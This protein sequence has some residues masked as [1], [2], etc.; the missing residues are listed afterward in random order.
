M[1]IDLIIFITVIVVTIIV[2][3]WDMH[4]EQ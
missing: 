3:A 2:V 1:D 4:D